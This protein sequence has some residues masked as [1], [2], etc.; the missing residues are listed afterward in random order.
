MRSIGATEGLDTLHEVSFLM[1]RAVCVRFKLEHC[2][3]NFRRGKTSRSRGR[4]FSPRGHSSVGSARTVEAMIAG[5]DPGREHFFCRYFLRLFF[6][7]F[8]GIQKHPNLMQ[9]ARSVS[10][11]NLN[12]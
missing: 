4:E 3:E 8:G 5:F 12:K 2:Y 11:I 10:G 7:V 1:Q 9:T 6:A